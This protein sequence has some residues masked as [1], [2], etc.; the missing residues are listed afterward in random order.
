[1]NIQEIAGVEGEREPCSRVHLFISNAQTGHKV[2]CL[3][4]PDSVCRTLNK[5]HEVFVPQC[6][7]IENGDKTAMD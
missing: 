4:L 5:L 6:P 7:Y 3:V 2:R 1:M